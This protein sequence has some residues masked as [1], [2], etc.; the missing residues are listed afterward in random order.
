MNSEYEYKTYYYYEYVLGSKEVT[1]REYEDYEDPV[2]NLVNVNINR[3]G[4]TR[5]YMRSDSADAKDIFMKGISEI[6]SN[7]MDAT[8]RAYELSSGRFHQFN[9]FWME[10]DKNN[11]VERI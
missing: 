5:F 9:N 11:E 6:L 3:L 7:D 8:Y 4:E 10:Q 2:L 1:I